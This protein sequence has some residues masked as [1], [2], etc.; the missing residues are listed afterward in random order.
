MWT[1]TIDNCDTYLGE[2]TGKYEWRAIRYRAAADF[3]KANGLSDSDTVMDIG[4]GWTEFDYCL[5]VEYGWRGRY[6]PIDGGIDGT[7][8]NEWC[9]IRKVEW[10]VGLEI[11]EHVREPFALVNRCRAMT[12]KG[13]VISTPNPRTTDVLGMDPT[14]VSEITALELYKAGFSGEERSFYGQPDDSLFATWLRK[15]A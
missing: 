4:A 14:H 12:T 13:M 9:P 5:R 2:R 3:L 6:I 1:P 8:L 11:I 10:V 15:E 7:D